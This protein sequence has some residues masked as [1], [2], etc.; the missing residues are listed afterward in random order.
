MRNLWLFPLLFLFQASP[1]FAQLTFPEVDRETYRFYLNQEWDSLLTLGKEA[2]KHDIDYFYL[3][4]RMGTARYE[5]GQY[6]LATEQ[7]R[8]ARNFNGADSYTNASLYY[9]LLASNRPSEA[10]ALTATFPEE[11]KKEVGFQRRILDLLSLELGYTLSDAYRKSDP[12]ALMGPDSIY[13]QQDLYGDSYYGYLQGTLNVSKRVSLT[14]GYS[15]LNFRKRKLFQ[16]TT[17]AQTRNPSFD[18]HL[19]QHEAHLGSSIRLVDGFR[20]EPAIHLVFGSSTNISAAYILQEED[21]RIRQQDTSFINMVASLML[22]KDFG[23]LSAGLFGSWSNLNDR[24]QV[25]AGISLTYYPLGNLSFYG[26]TMLFALM[27]SGNGRVIILQMLGV[28]VTKWLWAEGDFLFGNIANGNLGNGLIVY[29]NS[30]RVRFRAGGSL[31]F[32]LFRQLDLALVY[33]FFERESE[34]RFFVNGTDGTREVVV[35]QTRVMKYQTNSVFLG[36]KWK[37]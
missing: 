31:I 15:Y 30:D 22:T 33:Q 29:N 1:G 3:R 24:T 35:Q 8:K 18:Y 19:T 34:I 37:L 16:F 21:Y 26:N 36:L 2:L 28:K 20:I 6:I 9:S 25:Q 4:V 17:A 14:V 7:Y 11:L 13:G 27:E 12:R 23:I 32:P 10:Y 5:K